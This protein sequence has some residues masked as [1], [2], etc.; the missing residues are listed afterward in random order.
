MSSVRRPQGA[1]RDLLGTGGA[2]PRDHVT[3]VQRTNGLGVADR[4]EG[5]GLHG[6]DVA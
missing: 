1:E 3:H 2:V 6:T 5:A 4:A